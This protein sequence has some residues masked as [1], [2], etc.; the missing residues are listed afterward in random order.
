MTGWGEPRP[1]WPVGTATGVGSLPGGDPW[2]ACRLVFEELPDL[3]HLPEL[4]GR[5]APAS[6][7]ARA[8]A[9]LVEL[10]VD[11]QPAGWR[12]VARESLD[13]RRAR[14]LLAQDLDALEEV[15]QTYA[16]PLKLQVTGPLTLASM[17]ERPRGDL[18]LGDHGA[19]YDLAQ[20][21]I[22]GVVTQLA[23]VRRRVA[24]ARPVVQFDEPMLSSVLAGSVPTASGFSR[25]R[26]VHESE[27]RDTLAELVEAIH[28][29]GGVPVVHSCGAEVPF[30]LL[31]SSGVEAMSFDLARVPNSELDALAAVVDRGV[32]LWVGAVP[33]LEPDGPPPSDAELTRTVLQFWRGLGFADEQAS[34]ACVLTPACGLANAS[35]AWSRE[36]LV[37]A[38]KAAAN[39]VSEVGAG[40]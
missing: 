35:P 33:A 36:A 12:L 25:H 13:E 9:L 1:P 27:V 7:V 32:Q 39:L 28:G 18:V 5:G 4:P 23:E 26:A 3:P 34:L 17:V 29:V 11:L 40:S 19:R 37:L 20:S 31:A 2:A 14:A 24:G 15:A 6:M 8:C 10:H 30:E 38:R 21:L 22:E 16:G